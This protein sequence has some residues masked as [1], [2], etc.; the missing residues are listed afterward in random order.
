VP[1]GTR[2]ALPEG[3]RSTSV[4]KLTAHTPG[5]G[6]SQIRVEGRLDAAG[7]ASLRSR[8]DSLPPGATLDLSGLT[9]IDR[10]GAAFLIRLREAGVALRGGSLYITRLLEEV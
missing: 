8:L 10:E 1:I 5:R 7:I 6:P 3:D 4:I 2:L 9:S